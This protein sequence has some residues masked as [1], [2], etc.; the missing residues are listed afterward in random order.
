MVPDHAVHDDGK[1]AIWLK[2][3]DYPITIRAEH[4]SLVAKTNQQARC[5]TST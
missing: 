4:L 2:G 3:Y 5:L 1:V